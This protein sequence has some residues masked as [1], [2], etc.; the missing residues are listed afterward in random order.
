M[1]KELTIFT[2]TYNRCENLKKLYD[3]LKKQKNDNFTWLIID[4]GS[5]DNTNQYIKQIQS[6]ALI[7]VEYYYKDN[8]GKISAFNIALE[9]CKTKYFMCVDSDDVLM[10]N[11]IEK[12]YNKLEFI[13]EGKIGLV[14]PR[15][16]KKITE[17]DLQ[18]FNFKA[19]D[20][21]DLKFLTNK[22]IET[23]IVFETTYVKKIKFPIVQNENFMSEE[24]LYN[25]LSSVGKFVCIN[26]FVVESEYLDNGLTTNL[27]N[28]YK[29]NFY[30]TIMLFNSRF[31]FLDKYK[32][33]IKYINKLKTIININALCFYARKG[34]WANTPSKILSFVLIPISL[35][36]GKK[37]YGKRVN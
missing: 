21:M 11:D 32:F 34:I 33:K 16:S 36:W 20:I 10:K 15:K 35:L 31:F 28:N 22:T 6:E 2:P 29:K 5:T 27:Y 23:T 17:K 3:S 8:G 30:S 25:K 37:I 14:F 13:N 18:S 4:D 7:H 9:K 12:V 1:K 24:I 19:I 26:E